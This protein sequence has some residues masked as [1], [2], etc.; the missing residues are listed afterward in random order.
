METSP[1]IDENIEL[2]TLAEDFFGIE[3]PIDKKIFEESFQENFGKTELYLKVIQQINNPLFFYIESE[4]KVVKEEDLVTCWQCNGSGS[5]YEFYPAGGVNVYP[6][7]VCKSKGKILKRNVKQTL[8]VK[9]VLEM[10]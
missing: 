8:N 4:I 3:F 1:I 10:N 9:P 6:C 7:D 5:M 2:L